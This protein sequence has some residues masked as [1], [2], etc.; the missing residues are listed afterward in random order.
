VTDVS[1]LLDEVARHPTEGWDFTWLDER[2]TTD[3]LP[4]DYA[5]I[6]TGLARTSPDLLDL[7]TG[8]GEWLAQLSFRPVRTV[9][10]EAWPPNIAVARRRLEPL[11]VE[12]HAVEGVPDNNDQFAVGDATSLPFDDGAFHLVSCRHESFDAR[13][14][15]RVLCG[16]GH[17]V[18]QQVGDG[19]FR[20]FRAL[21]DA[22]QSTLAPLTLEMLCAQV[23]ESGMYVSESNE[24]VKTV[25]FHDVGALAW[26]L[27]MVPW[28]VPGF[29]VVAQRDT[30][31]RLHREIERSGPLRVPQTGMYLV[32][33]KR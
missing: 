28:T 19:L 13:E 21:F 24:S 29:D 2:I 30:L 15:A 4:W 22:P 32:A 16:G 7:G 33:R 25:S 10:T 8:G 1:E 26:Y 23:W 9:A 17:F 27:T 31:N 18:T 5:E 11:G 6:V 12:V 14:V 20:E 3:T